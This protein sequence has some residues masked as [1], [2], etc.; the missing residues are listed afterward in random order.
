MRRVFVWTC[1]AL[2]RFAQTCISHARRNSWCCLLEWTCLESAGLPSLAC[3]TRAT[4]QV[5]LVLPCLLIPYGQDS[6]LP[7]ITCFE[8][9][10]LAYFCLSHMGKISWCRLQA[11][12]CLKVP[13][14]A[15]TCAISMSRASWCRQLAWTR[16]DLPRLASSK[17]TG[18]PGA[19]CL[20]GLAWTCA[21]RH[22]R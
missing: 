15:Y 13:K 1:R 11:W 19:A 17:W 18:L 14:F 6:L 2:L 21:T 10:R 5:F 9:H 22:S 16:S 3:S 4:F 20:P 7:L 8:V 12:T